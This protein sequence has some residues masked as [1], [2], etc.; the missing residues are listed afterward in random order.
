M[1][2]PTLR[3]KILRHILWPLSLTWALGTCI[4]LGLAY[5]FTSSAYDRALL[6]DALSLSAQVRGDDQLDQQGSF[7]PR[8]LLSDAE[9]RSVLFDPTDIIYFSVWRADGTLLSGY[10]DL[11]PTSNAKFQTKPDWRNATY[12]GQDV[13][14]VSL[15]RNLPA[16]HLVLVGQTTASRRAMLRRV[17]LASVFPQIVLL[18]LLA[19]WLSRR[20][21]FDLKPL[22]ELQTAVGL[23]DTSDLGHVPYG[24]SQGAGTSTIQSLGI[25]INA[26]FD[27]L[28]QGIKAQREFSGNVAHELRTPLSTIRLSAEQ[29]LTVAS[30]STTQN[31]LRK[32][33]SSTDQASHL[34]DQL[35]A[36]AFANEA[37]FN[38]PLKR[39]DLT[40]LVRDI[41]VKHLPR[42]AA[43]ERHGWI[44][45]GAE[46][47]DLPVYVW[48][49]AVLIEAALDNLI[50]NAFGYGLP[51]TGQQAKI[52][53]AVCVNLQDS[54]VALQ[55]MDN[56]GGLSPQE[57]LQLT[58]RWNQ[59]DSPALSTTA[60]F[61]RLPGL[62]SKR[63]VGLGLYIVSR[64]A[65]L[66]QAPLSLLPNPSGQGLCAQLKFKHELST[67][68]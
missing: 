8:L 57:R 58:A 4:A 5:Y 51:L 52:T 17:L 2:K 42:C 34:I 40:E 24:L 11:R 49:H 19:W 50:D 47:L 56:G 1:N 15:F 29:A 3:Q 60:P 9:M 20:V 23:R 39:L 31:A 67:D 59:A 6:D 16:P 36:L 25:A 54:A 63:G 14:V 44:D 32:L 61:A 22:L 65:Q 13:R 7:L 21:E 45:L 66:L 30:D 27:R 46:G 55:V 41:V 53:V 37:A 12:L 33:L 35:L 26:L 10:K 68:L 18:F 48:G 64:Y 38:L 28:E 62:A 43:T